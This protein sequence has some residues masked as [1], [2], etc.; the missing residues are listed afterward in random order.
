LDGEENSRILMLLLQ[1]VLRAAALAALFSSRVLL[2]AG[3]ELSQ[4][5]IDKWEPAIKAF[6]KQ[7]AENPPATGGVVFVGSSSIRK[8]DLPKWF[9]ENAPLNRGFGGSQIADVNFFAARIV[10][11]HKPRGIVFYAGDND[12]AAM[13]SASDVA[14]DFE[15]FCKLVH[16]KLPRTKIAFIAIKPSPKRW[17][18]KD[19]QSKANAL[20][21][22]QCEADERLTFVD[23][24][25]A[26]LDSKG[27]P[28]AELFVE[29]K[30]HLNEAGYKLWTETVRPILAKFEQ[31]T[32]S[33][34]P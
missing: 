18:L 28:R 17:A 32:A 34:L 26:M 24:W 23:V 21:R 16:A 15:K 31:P 25:P 22:K 29:D 7:D 14:V 10:L 4:E 6:E 13:V 33:Q 30:L 20:I 27:E 8:W 12:I 11:K 1:D 19:E 9:G 3:Q 5:R 2:A